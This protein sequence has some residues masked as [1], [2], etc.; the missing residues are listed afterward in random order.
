MKHI[1]R[2]NEALDENFREELQDFCE[3]NLA[4][5]LD[6]GTEIK[7]EYQYSTMHMLTITLDEPTGWPSIKDHMI[8]FLIILNNQYDIIKVAY[9]NTS[10]K[11]PTPHDVSIKAIVLKH[12]IANRTLDIPF[13]IKDLIENKNTLYSFQID[14]LVISEFQ[15]FIEN[16]LY[17][18][19]E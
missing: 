6:E 1:K 7:I 11:K 14:D 2:F 16:H 9:S 18:I 13:L 8:P 15:L 19:K 4:Y 10:N 3:L 12:P 17:D 5:L